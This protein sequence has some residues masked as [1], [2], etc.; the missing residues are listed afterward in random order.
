[1]KRFFKSLIITLMIGLPLVMILLVVIYFNQKERYLSIIQETPVSIES[2]LP[3]KNHSKPSNEKEAVPE[4]RCW[5][6]YPVTGRSSVPEE[7]IPKTSDSVTISF[8]GDVH[9][10][11][12]ALDSYDKPKKAEKTKSLWE[13]FKEAVGKFFG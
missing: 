12:L 6:G 10:S 9:F 13:K 3:E 1:M 2:L 8:A 4:E 5:Y 11:E 7:Q